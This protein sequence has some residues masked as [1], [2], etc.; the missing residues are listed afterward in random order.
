[1][2]IS[3]WSSDVCSSDLLSEVGRLNQIEV[4]QDEANKALFMEAQRHPGQEQQV[5]EYYRSNPQA[6]AQLR[7]P[8]FEDK[9]T[10]FLLDLATVTERAVTAD[11]L[12]AEEEKAAAEKPKTA[13]QPTAKQAATKANEAHNK[14]K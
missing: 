2:R 9:V 6:Q 11:E 12:R 1:M 5:V 10:D 8:L 7:A 4:T 3:D 14:K 13:A